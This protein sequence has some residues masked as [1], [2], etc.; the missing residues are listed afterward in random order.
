MKNLFKNQTND[1]MPSSI[2]YIV[3]CGESRLHSYFL[4]YCEQ[5]LTTHY[6]RETE[7]PYCKYLLCVYMYID[8]PNLKA[9]N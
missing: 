6:V 8:V 2:A 3:G 5:R 4:I 7:N 1:L 9:L